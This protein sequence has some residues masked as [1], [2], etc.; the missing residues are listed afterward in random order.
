MDV[1][2]LFKLT[3]GFRRLNT[4][5]SKHNQKNVLHDNEVYFIYVCM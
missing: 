5:M 1:H 4:D 3:S 2:T